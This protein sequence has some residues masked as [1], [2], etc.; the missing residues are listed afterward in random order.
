MQ[1]PKTKQWENKEY[2][3]IWVDQWNI[4][5][6]PVRFDFEQS[7]PYAP[8]PEEWPTQYKQF[9]EQ[10]EQVG[11]IPISEIP[12]LQSHEIEQLKFTGLTSAEEIAGLPDAQLN[13]LGLEGRKLRERVRSY[14]KFINSDSRKAA[15]VNEELT[16][17][18][19]EQQEELEE[20]KKQM[21]EIVMGKASKKRGKPPKQVEQMV[22]SEQQEVTI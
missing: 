17:K 18:V 7:Q 22:S 14:L 20:L 4:Q 6:R 10:K 3:K 1:N 19:K 12:G 8:D 15:I 2:V 5:E 16:T 21:Q 9:K 11:G 13:R